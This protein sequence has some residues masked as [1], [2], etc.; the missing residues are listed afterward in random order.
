MIAQISVLETVTP[1]DFLDFRCVYVPVSV[2]THSTSVPLPTVKIN[3]V[4][5]LLL[6]TNRG[7]LTPASGF[8]STQFRLLEIRL[9]LKEEQRVK[10][11]HCS[12]T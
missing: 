5:I 1:L 4:T 8:Q 9:G 3:L 2:F 7:F 6:L 11:A 12:F 10:Y